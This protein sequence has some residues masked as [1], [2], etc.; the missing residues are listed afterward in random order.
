MFIDNGI[1]ILLFYYYYVLLSIN[2]P[3]L[4]KEIIRRSQT[5]FPLE[6]LLDY[7][8]KSIHYLLICLYHDL[9]E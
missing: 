7:R 2:H 3:A 8:A 1:S 5:T 6:L 9:V 4:G